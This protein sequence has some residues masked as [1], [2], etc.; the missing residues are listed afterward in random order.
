MSVLLFSISIDTLHPFYYVAIKYLGTKYKYGGMDENGMDCSGFLY[1]VL[2]EFNIKPPRTSF[3]Y[4]NFGKPVSLDSVKP[5]DVLIF[6]FKQDYDHVG[7]YIGDNKII[8]AS[9][10][11]GV[12]IE[13]LKYIG[14]YL[15]LARRIY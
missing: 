13:D 10:N 2:S 1:R 12:I 6:S 5:G 11:R 8:H 3:D 14:K 7:I 15:K 9:R 4:L